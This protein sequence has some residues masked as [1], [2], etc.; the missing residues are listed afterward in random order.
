MRILL[1]LLNTRLP[2]PAL[3]RWNLSY[4]ASELS[5]KVNQAN[6]DLCGCCFAELE[7]QP[8]TYLEPFVLY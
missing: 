4:S 6:E 7:P 1:R 5:R 2:A 8:D 3:G